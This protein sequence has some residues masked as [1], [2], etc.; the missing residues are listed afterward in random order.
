L[1]SLEQHP[2]TLEQSRT[3]T[4]LWASGGGGV[5]VRLGSLRRETSG[6]TG[7][8]LQL[9]DVGVGSR[10]AIAFSSEND[11]C[12]IATKFISIF[13]APCHKSI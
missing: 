10:M 9:K 4:E 13:K 2:G 12:P 5:F 7:S 3:R 8:G 11:L 1:H 6:I